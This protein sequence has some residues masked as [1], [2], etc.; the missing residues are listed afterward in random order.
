MAKLIGIL[1]A[2]ALALAIMDL[3][4]GPHNGDRHRFFIHVAEFVFFFGF[5]CFLQ[6]WAFRTVTTRANLN[7]WLVMTCLSILTC[8]LSLILFA[9]SGGS[10]HGDGGPTAFS[11]LLLWTIGSVLAP[12]SFVGFVVVAISR[13]RKGTLILDK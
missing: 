13:K 3:V 9:V 7:R 2:C 8:V 1:G 10:F 4:H 11:F 5:L 12:I 6:A